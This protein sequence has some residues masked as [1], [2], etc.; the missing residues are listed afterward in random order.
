[1][2]K[3]QLEV[4]LAYGGQAPREK[5]SEL[6]ELGTGKHC[7][8][9]QTLFLPESSLSLIN[10]CPQAT[11]IYKQKGMHMKC[12]SKLKQIQDETWKLIFIQH[13]FEK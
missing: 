1:V 2:C 12:A 10:T 6:N 5:S 8:K 4:C 11:D 3:P 7:A 13:Y 9:D